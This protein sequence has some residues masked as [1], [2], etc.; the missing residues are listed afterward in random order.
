MNHLGLPAVLL[1]DVLTVKLLSLVR[2]YPRQFEQQPA[3]RFNE[4]ESEN[5]TLFCWLMSEMAISKTRSNE[6]QERCV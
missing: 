3:N 4:S 1:E 5:A 6:K 2:N